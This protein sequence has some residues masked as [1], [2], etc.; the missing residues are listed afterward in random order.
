MALDA[1]KQGYALLAAFRNAGPDGLDWED[2]IER[3]GGI[4]KSKFGNPRF[5]NAPKPLMTVLEDAVESREL[6]LNWLGLYA[7]TA[8]GL[9]NC[10]FIEERFIDADAALD[11]A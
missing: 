11:H 4:A 8:K 5:V 7:I 1:T 2:M 9:G 3:M 6:A 10:Q